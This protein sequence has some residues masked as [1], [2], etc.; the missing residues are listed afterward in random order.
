MSKKRSFKFDS[1][2]N[3]ELRALISGISFLTRLPLPDFIHAR[4]DDQNARLDFRRSLYWFP[5]VG[6]LL[7]AILALIDRPLLLIFP[8]PLA[9][10][11]LLLFYLVLTGGLH[12]DGLMDSADGLLSGRPPEKIPEIMR[13]SSSG[14]FAVLAAII[15]LLLKFLCFW[16]LID[17]WRIGGL[18]IMPVISRLIMAVGLIKLPVLSDSLAEVFSARLNFARMLHLAA[19]ALALILL[20]PTFDLLPFH[21]IIISA[22][23]ALV[24]T[25]LISRGVISLLGGMTGDIFGMLNEVDELIVLIVLLGLQ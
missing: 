11:L 25:V 1:S 13:D 17:S 2:V 24:F 4:M 16:L 18:I 23:T 15:Y 8:R 12:L 21:V 20:L 19:A 5:V 7:G 10:G 9:A 6:M 14:A 3:R 22:A